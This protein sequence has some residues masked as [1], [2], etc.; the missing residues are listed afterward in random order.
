MSSFHWREAI[1]FAVIGAFCGY[2]FAQ[3]D[4]GT[5]HAAEFAR[6][7]LQQ[8][9]PENIA[10][11]MRAAGYEFSDTQCK[12]AEIVF[13]QQRLVNAAELIAAR[14]A[15]LEPFIDQYLQKHP[16]QSRTVAEL[17]VLD[18]AKDEIERRQPSS[19]YEGVA[20]CYK[21]LKTKRDGAG[22]LGAGGTARPD[23]QAR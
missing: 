10:L 2:V 17:M 7:R 18:A 21:R 9:S 4:K 23:S 20:S 15:A 5:D 14:R 12:D 1:F 8:Q 16:G 6:C 13:E 11:C 22:W 19:K 3:F